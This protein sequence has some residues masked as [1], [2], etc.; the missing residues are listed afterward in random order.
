ME[1]RSRKRSRKASERDEVSEEPSPP[2]VKARRRSSGGKPCDGEEK[3][4][5]GNARSKRR[6]LR[7][8]FDIV[9]NN[10]SVGE[11]ES[12]TTSGAQCTLTLAS[13]S[14]NGPPAE[15]PPP[16][17][18]KDTTKKPQSVEIKFKRPD[19]TVSWSGVRL[20]VATAGSFPSWQA[21]RRRR[22]GATNRLWLPRELCSGDPLTPHV[23]KPRPLGVA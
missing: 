17:V 9:E 6:G 10:L 14:K 22:G 19:F 23:R 4:K 15:S 3:K 18:A 7:V 13:S 20:L 12:A 11:S 1:K 21:T 2:L 5:R 8:S 16:T